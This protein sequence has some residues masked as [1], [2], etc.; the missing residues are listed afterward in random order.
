[1][2]SYS[3]DL[4]RTAQRNWTC[5]KCAAQI[6]VGTKYR[7][8]AHYAHNKWNHTRRHLTCPTDEYPIPVLL[9]DGTKEWLLGSVHDMEGKEVFLTRDWI[10]DKYYFRPCV[11]NEH[12]EVIIWR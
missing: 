1:M 11:F 7:D 4:I 8:V 2:S 3:Y 9:E 12:M 10:D 5:A 6:L